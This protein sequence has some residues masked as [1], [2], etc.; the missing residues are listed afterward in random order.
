MKRMD[1]NASTK[2]LMRNGGVTNSHIS[3]EDFVSVGA[4]L[5]STSGELFKIRIV[6]VQRFVPIVCQFLDAGRIV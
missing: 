3:S 1:A 5:S 6:L 4:I 2:V